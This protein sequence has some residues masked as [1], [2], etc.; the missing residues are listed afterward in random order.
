MY[1]EY[2]LRYKTWKLPSALLPKVYRVE[3]ACQIIFYMFC[4]R[5][6]NIVQRAH[7]HSCSH[8]AIIHTLTLEPIDSNAYHSV[9]YHYHILHFIYLCCVMLICEYVLIMDAFREAFMLMI[10]DECGGNCRLNLRTML[11]KS[12]TKVPYLVVW[13]T[14]FFNIIIFDSKDIDRQRLLMKI[15]SADVITYVIVNPRST[16]CNR[17]WHKSNIYYKNSI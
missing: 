5:I 7:N 16:N 17:E 10:L 3:I 6:L 2:F 8:R 14:D 4:N 13:K 15:T 9:R 11:F 1:D 12:P